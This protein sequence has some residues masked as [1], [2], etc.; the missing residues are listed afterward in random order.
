M[1]KGI[2]KLIHR[3]NHLHCR[4]A[5]RCVKHGWVKGI[6]K[7]IHRYNHFTLQASMEVCKAW[8]LVVLACLVSPACC[9]PQESAGEAAVGEQKPF[10]SS[11]DASHFQESVDDSQ[12]DYL[13]DVSSV[14]RGGKSDGCV[15]PNTF[16]IG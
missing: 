13:K 3:Y 5:W 10:E 16:L 6:K 11:S 9:Q 8:L 12:D 14:R 1:V 4:L 2:K 7:L 15:C